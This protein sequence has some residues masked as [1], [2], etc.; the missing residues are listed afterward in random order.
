M[1][2]PSEGKRGTLSA[3]QLWLMGRD[4]VNSF[5]LL[6]STTQGLVPPVPLVLSLLNSPP[7]LWTQLQHLMVLEVAARAFFF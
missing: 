7:L 4:L 5:L 3:A 2:F 6:L 1:P